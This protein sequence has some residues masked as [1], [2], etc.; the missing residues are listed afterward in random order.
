MCHELYKCDNRFV[1]G[2]VFSFI[3]KQLLIIQKEKQYPAF[4]HTYLSPVHMDTS[5]AI[6]LPAFLY[7]IISY[8]VRHYSRTNLSLFLLF[9]PRRRPSPQQGISG[10][11]LSLS[12]VWLGLGDHLHSSEGLLNKVT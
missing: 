10:L 8:T 9:P 6:S 7:Q 3:R 12:S 11:F 2:N 1:A 5:V 4:L